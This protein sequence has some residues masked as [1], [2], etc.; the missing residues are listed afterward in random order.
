[1]FGCLFFNIKII[2]KKKESVK[3]SLKVF[4]IFFFMFNLFTKIIL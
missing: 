4:K 2:M 3:I 1:M